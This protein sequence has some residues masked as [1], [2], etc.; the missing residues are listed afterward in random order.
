MIDVLSERIA[1]LAHI[2]AERGLD[3]LLI[4]QPSRTILHPAKNFQRSE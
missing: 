4:D 3:A 2:A 1:A